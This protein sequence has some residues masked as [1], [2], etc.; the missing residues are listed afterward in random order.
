MRQCENHE[1]NLQK[2]FSV[3]LTQAFTLMHRYEWL[4][5]SYVAEFFIN[6]SWEKFPI[7]WRK[8]FEKLTLEE[9]A[10]NIMT[11]KKNRTFRFVWPLSLLAFISSC[12]SLSLNRTQK[13]SLPTKDEIVNQ[14]KIFSKHIKPKKRHELSLFPNIVHQ[15]C[16]K[17]NSKT[18]V[19][20]GSGLGH[21][22][23]MLAYLYD[24][25]V[26]AIE[27]EGQRLPLAG[28]FDKD[29]ENELKRISRD[30]EIK[31][32]EVRH[33]A[34][35]INPNINTEEFV[36][37][38]KDKR[39]EKLNCVLVGLHT[40]GDLA[41][42]M[43][44]V[45]NNTSII[46]GIVSASCCYFR[47]TLLEKD[48]GRYN[49]CWIESI[50]NGVTENTLNRQSEIDVTETE[51]KLET[52]DDSFKLKAVPQ[53]VGVE[54]LGL[55]CVNSNN[56]ACSH[57]TMSHLQSIYSSFNGD[58]STNCYYSNYK[59]SSS[60]H[61][62]HKSEYQFQ[63][64]FPL[65]VF[66]QRFDYQPLRYK[67]FEVA[68]HFVDDYIKKLMSNSPNLKLH[69]YR[70]VMEVFI[71]F[72]DPKLVMASV[73]CKKIKN[74]A[75][76]SFEEYA[77]KVFERLQIKLDLQLLEKI[78]Y[79]QLLAQWKNVVIYH[80]IIHLMGPV[81]ESIALVD[82][83]M[84]LVELGYSASLVPVFDPKLSPRNFVLI[85]TKE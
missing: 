31:F 28:K 62:E 75:L 4:A 57:F 20:V 81:V 56:Q 6:N 49:S 84:F 55:I 11:N 40:C 80:S 37:L 21:L 25:S 47:M 17:T 15:V 71:R 5:N 59:N 60:N 58:K 12:H 8:C 67:C 69:C 53:Q 44:N 43:L 83:W 64:G 30:K 16:E 10:N 42:T 79:R 41:S 77:E 34:K 38:I 61:T 3:Y 26:T 32:G 74:A 72:V 9:I 2:Q 65:S 22:S 54:K 48:Y 50:K 70:A 7:A 76:L 45:F 63:Y 18:V 51:N 23:R 14:S 52:C 85:A 27:M 78:N 66:L 33:I 82:K 73:R 46:K 68:C 24:Y 19:D 36:S 29:L 1:N 13:K 39:K 35:L